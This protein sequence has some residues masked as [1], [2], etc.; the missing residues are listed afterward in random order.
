[1]ARQK[2][3]EINH[4]EAS[5]LTAAGLEG[6]LGS[7]DMFVSSK[8]IVI[9]GLASLTKSKK[10]DE[11]IDLV[12]K[13]ADTA[14]IVLWEAKKLTPTLLK[15][16]DH[17]KQQVF[18]LSSSLFEWLD[19]LHGPVPRRLALLQ[20]AAKQDG[21]DFC[22]AMFTRQV[23]LLLLTKSGEPM[24]EH[25]FVIQ[26]LQKQATVFTLPQLIKI[27]EQL[28]MMDFRQKTGRSRLTTQQELEEILMSM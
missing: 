1:M 11:L 14:D 12:I 25:P 24:K 9:E 15:K 20:Q 3:S 10:K 6:E 23:R 28:T 18:P 16:F 13:Y 17:A 7:Q 27:H 4:I 2:G 5:G 21:I 8:L 22:F 19:S 26:K